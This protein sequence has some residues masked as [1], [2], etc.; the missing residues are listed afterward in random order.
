VQS[1]TSVNAPYTYQP[2]WGP[3]TPTNG[4]TMV[5]APWYF[6]FGLKKGKTAMDKFYSTYIDRI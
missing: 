3:K 6:Y 1:G 5:S 2:N 4:L